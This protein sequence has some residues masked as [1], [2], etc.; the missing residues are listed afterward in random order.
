MPPSDMLPLPPSIDDSGL[1]RLAYMPNA[2]I[3]RNDRR[4]DTDAGSRIAEKPEVQVC[5]RSRKHELVRASRQYDS[6]A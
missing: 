3:S 5:Q 4:D 2:Q 6:S 1:S